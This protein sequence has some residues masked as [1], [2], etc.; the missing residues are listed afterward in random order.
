MHISWADL[1]RPQPPVAGTTARNSPS[2]FWV[3]VPPPLGGLPARRFSAAGGGV[4]GRAGRGKGGLCRGKPRE[5]HA[6]RRA[7]HVVEAELV[8]ERDRLRLA[9]VL[10]ADT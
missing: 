8:A 1:V 7:R 10:A 9:A 3:A 2:A 5:R 4:R 6:V